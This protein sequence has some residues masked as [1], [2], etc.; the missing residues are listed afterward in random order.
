MLFAEA[1]DALSREPMKVARDMHVQIKVLRHSV[2][3][4]M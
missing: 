2:A 4:S 3:E 1:L